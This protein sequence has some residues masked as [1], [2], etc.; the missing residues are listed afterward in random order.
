MAQVMWS[1]DMTLNYNAEAVALSQ[2][3]VCLGPCHWAPIICRNTWVWFL[4]AVWGRPCTTT[5][6]LPITWRL[7]SQPSAL[8]RAD[9]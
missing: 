2:F 3:G 6:A 7:V 5:P 4:A 9:S 1:G 8:R